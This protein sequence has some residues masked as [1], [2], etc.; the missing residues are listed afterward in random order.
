MTQLDQATLQQLYEQGLLSQTTYL[1]LL[2][3]QPLFTQQDLNDEIAGLSLPVTPPTAYLLPQTAVF[4]E[5]QPDDSPSLDLALDAEITAALTEPAAQ[6]A[7]G[8][9]QLFGNPVTPLNPI[10]GPLPFGQARRDAITTAETPTR[11]GLPVIQ[12]PRYSPPDQMRTQWR[13]LQGEF[14]NERLGVPHTMVQRQP[15]P[16]SV[17]VTCVL[18][19]PGLT[20]TTEHPVDQLRVIEGLLHLVLRIGNPEQI[21]LPYTD[22][23][24]NLVQSAFTAVAQA[25]INGGVRKRIG[26]SVTLFDAPSSRTLPWS[27]LDCA[28]ITDTAPL[29][30]KQLNAPSTI[31]ATRIFLLG[32]GVT[33]EDRQQK[34]AESRYWKRSRI[35][36]FP[37]TGGFAAKSATSDK[38]DIVW[39]HSEPTDRDW[40]TRFLYILDG[41]EA[42]I[43]VRH[44]AALAAYDLRPD[45]GKIQAANFTAGRSADHGGD[46]PPLC[47]DFQ[48]LQ[49]RSGHHPWSAQQPERLGTAYSEHLAPPFTPNQT[50]QQFLDSIAGELGHES[51]GSP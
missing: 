28:L 20:G 34:L 26:R 8:P 6:P 18:A 30:Q 10:G 11:L 51:P 24:F 49:G 27:E 45:G 25:A 38:V 13:N 40:K 46:P 12:E 17:P 48:G 2:Q 42:A 41:Y 15:E 43:A 35:V 22:W 33:H 19:L 9:I 29:V 16:K 31:E 50:H 44:G 39:N 1:S 47:T 32:G 23:I 14:Y 5:F 37:S 7:A 4:A 36:T 21:Y 3:P